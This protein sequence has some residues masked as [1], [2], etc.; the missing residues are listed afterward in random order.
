[1]AHLVR[2]Y[3]YVRQFPVDREV[4]E[5]LG[6]ATEGIVDVAGGEHFDVPV[7]VNLNLE[8]GSLKVTAAVV[9][10]LFSTYYFVGNYK[11]F[12]EGV[13]EICKDANNFGYDFCD[14]FLMRAGIVQSQISKQEVKLETP[15][16]LRSLMDDLEKLSDESLPEELRRQSLPLESRRIRLSNLAT[17]L[18]LILHDVS[19][20][21]QLAITNSLKFENLPPISQWPREKRKV[22][23]LRLARESVPE[24][25]YERD[26]KTVRSLKKRPLRYKKKVLVLPKKRKA[27]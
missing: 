4:L 26:V 6:H 24:I 27:P 11:A 7:E 10:A 14:K 17:K 9:G 2:V 15:S 1:M 5:R 20:Q 8:E 12:K 3:L 21:E 23:P 19:S 13:V 18:D 25:E 16:R 22:E